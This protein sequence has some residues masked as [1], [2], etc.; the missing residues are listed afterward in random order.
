MGFSVT[1]TD[2]SS[3]PGDLSCPIGDDGI[4]VSEWVRLLESTGFRTCDVLLRSAEKISCGFG[5]ALICLPA[6]N[7]VSIGTTGNHRLGQRVTTELLDLQ[8]EQ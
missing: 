4:P 8:V 5:E 3:V 7:S 1:T 6:L 2:C